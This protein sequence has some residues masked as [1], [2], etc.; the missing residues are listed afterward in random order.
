MGKANMRLN[1]K[2]RK[3]VNKQLLGL[4]L[5]LLWKL[6]CVLRPPKEYYKKRGRKPVDWRV[7]FC[8][9][10]LRVVLVRNFDQYESEME[11]DPRL[12]LFF[13]E[14]TG[15]HKLPS[16]SGIHRFSQLM[17]A[18]YLR[19]IMAVLVKPYAKGRVDLLLDATG[20]SLMSKSVWYCIRLGKKIEK[21]DCY[22][23]HAA[24]SLHWGLILNWRIT[25]GNRHESP[26]LNCLVRPFRV[27]GLVIAD[28]GYSSRANL[29]LVVDQGGSPFIKFKKN[30]TAQS[31][32]HPAWKVQHYFY[33]SMR[34]VW[35]QI[36]T[37]R[38]RIENVFSVLKGVWG[39]R[40]SSTN[41]K[42]RMRELM[43]R[44]IRIQHETDTLHPAQQETQ[45]APLGTGTKNVR[46]EANPP[47]HHKQSRGTSNPPPQCRRGKQPYQPHRRRQNAAGLEYKDKKQKKHNKHLE[48]NY[49]M[50]PIS[51]YYW[52]GHFVVF[53][54]L[55]YS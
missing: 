30:T 4:A 28:K 9:N 19:G 53:F 34:Y 6:A 48:I 8:L 14:V 18:A 33:T 32:N 35:N 3:Q 52:D 12:L 42:R 29:Q 31:K 46:K 47:F 27:L 22:K 51:P 37:R 24:I 25:R 5:T 20:I 54:S 45:P 44:F 40:L 26:F 15:I 11:G 10:L 43:L 38:N 23:L 7:P 1:P 13:N 41:K 21:R 49:G 39:D 16:R 36:Y 17:G 50:T 2:V 55:Y